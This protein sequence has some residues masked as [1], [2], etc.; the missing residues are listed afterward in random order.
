MIKNN[1][2]PV[3][4][5]EIVTRDITAEMATQD[6]VLRIYDKDMIGQQAMELG[7]EK[8]R[9]QGVAIVGLRN[10]HH[11]GRIGAW[12][13]ECARAGFISIHYV[14]GTGHGPL[15]ATHGGYEARYSTN[16]FCTAI[17]ATPDNP[18]IVVDFATSMIAQ[19]KVRVA[20]YAGNPLPEG[21]VVGPNGHATT[22]PGAA[23]GSSATV[24]AASGS[25]TLTTA[26]GS[27]AT[28]ATTIGPSSVAATNPRQSFAWPMLPRHQLQALQPTRGRC[29]LHERV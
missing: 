14:N 5:D 19:G 6:L 11:L 3:W 16:P 27:A 2:N 9:A 29:Q 8:A 28:I 17:P 25:A 26:T 21:V 12:G 20:H 13:E 4:S 15:V 23:P 7:L 24:A 18:M 10:V 22:A 1:L